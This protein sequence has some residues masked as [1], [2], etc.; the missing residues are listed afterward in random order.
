MKHLWYSVRGYWP[1]LPFAPVVVLMNW[2]LNSRGT[3]LSPQDWASNVILAFVV[4]LTGLMVSHRQA[5]R[6]E[7]LSE[8]EITEKIAVLSGTADKIE[9]DFTA[10]RV[11]QMLID[12]R[13]GLHLYPYSHQES[14]EEY[15][16]VL[17][18]AVARV[19]ETLHG[20]L[21]AYSDWSISDWGE[22]KNLLT[23]L[24]HAL[25]RRTKSRRKRDTAAVLDLSLHI[26]DMMLLPD[27]P[28][29]P[30][31]VFR[32]HFSE[33]NRHK[34]R[35]CL[36]WSV[37]EELV[38]RD[39]ASIV[40]KKGSEALVDL[41]QAYAPW[42]LD[43][44]GREVGWRDENGA[45]VRFSKIDEVYDLLAPHRHHIIDGFVE[46]ML[47]GDNESVPRVEVATLDMGLLGV[48]VLDGN[49]RLSAI[50]KYREGYDEPISVNFIEY[51]IKAPLDCRLVSDLEYHLRRSGKSA[52]LVSPLKVDRT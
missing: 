3:P 31:A 4:T 41:R 10:S 37:L 44:N 51:R 52:E 27:P 22:F 6:Q 23:L 48:L 8:N 9:A 2:V 1:L 18:E 40:I 47:K 24:G 5:Q 15:L 30:L 19:H 26:S 16:R 43:A 12:A 20:S 42:Y 7:A 21:R 45:A 36:D 49:H 35:V 39:A 46:S 11:R 17:R 34:I 28:S 38:R 13:A 33:R 29:V 32:R 50:L 14:R 25:D